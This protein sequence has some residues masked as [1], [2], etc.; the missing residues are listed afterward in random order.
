MKG[1]LNTFDQFAIDRKK[2]A[3]RIDTMLENK[4]QVTLK[5]VV[6]HYGIDNGLSEVVGYFSIASESEN[7]LILEEATEPITIGERILNMPDIF[8]VN[9]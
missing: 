4:T 8:N 7:H 9:I 3:T 5:E 1:Q 2:L 6:D